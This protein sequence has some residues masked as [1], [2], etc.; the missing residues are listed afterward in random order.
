[1]QPGIDGTQMAVL[2]GLQAV[3]SQLSASV[4]GSYKGQAVVIIPGANTSTVQD[5]LEELGVTLS[6]S[7]SKKLADRTTK[8]QSFTDRLHALMAKYV[9]AVPKSL[10]PDE[11]KQYVD[12]LKSQANPSSDELGRRLEERFGDDVEGQVATLEFLDELFSEHEHPAAKSTIRELKQQWRENDTQGPRLRAGQNI[13]AATSEF[14]VNVDS[15]A[16]LR[17]FYRTTVLGWDSLDDA[18]SSILERYAGDAF[19]TAT[20]FLMHALGCEIQSLGPSC[21]PQLLMAVRDDI[22][23]LQIV[24]RFHLQMRELT[25]RLEANFGIELCHP[26]KKEKRK[27]RK[28]S[29][30]KS[31]R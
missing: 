21:D 7:V 22:Y 20:D 4:T 28:R 24:R 13:R 3:Q 19:S 30:G 18:Y 31:S 23:Y 15:D 9:T 8:S 11:L 29:S 5:S 1:M 10:S 6:E 16:G 14:G 17:T 12:W 25:D 27:R 26:T 2:S